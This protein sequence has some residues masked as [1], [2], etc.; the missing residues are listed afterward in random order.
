MG[1]GEA[2]PKSRRWG[3]SRPRWSQ[4]RALFA[5][6][7]PTPCME[8]AAAGIEGRCSL[9]PKCGS[10]LAGVKAAALRVAFGQP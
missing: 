4:S 8:F 6:P 5:L 9:T 3:V 2:C 1:P 7:D 10:V